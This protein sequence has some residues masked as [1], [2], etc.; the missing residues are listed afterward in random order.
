[1]NINFLTTDCK[2]SN[3][4]EDLFGI[5]DDQNNTVAYTDLANPGKWIAKVINE[6]NIDVSFTPIDNC[7]IILKEGTK[8]KESTCDGMLTFENSI[9]LVE[10][11]KQITGGWISEAIGQLENTIQLIFSNH[12]LLE[13]KH[14]KAFACNRKHPYFKTMD[15]EFSKK[16]FKRT[17]GFRIDIQT[18]IKIK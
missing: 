4:S 17:N 1:M 15:N 6:K 2:E 8:D 11:K 3:R 13:F 5:C 7:I 14:K 18:E 9:Y 12:N 10:L 16:F